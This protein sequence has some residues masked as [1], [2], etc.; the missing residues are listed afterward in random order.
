MTMIVCGVVDRTSRGLLDYDVFLSSLYLWFL[1]PTS[2]VYRLETG[3][4]LLY[5][6]IVCILLHTHNWHYFLNRRCLL[7]ITA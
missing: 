6:S 1:T 3:L 4:L 5:D 2:L 7:H